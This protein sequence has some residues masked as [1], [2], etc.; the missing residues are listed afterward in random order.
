MEVFR[1]VNTHQESNSYFFYLSSKEIVMVDVGDFDISCFNQWL[2]SRNI[3]IRAVFLTHEHSD[4]CC[5]VNELLQYYDFD[6][7][8]SKSCAI[9]IKDPKQNFSKYIDSIDSFKISKDSIVVG[10]RTKIKLND[11]NFTIIET[12]GHSPGSICIVV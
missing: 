6:L 8:C 12:P 5:G 4:H 11:F 3:K 1:I 9:N 7:F 10:D 2:I